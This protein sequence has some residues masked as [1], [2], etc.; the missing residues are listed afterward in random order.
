VVGRFGREVCHR[1]SRATP[2][3]WMLAAIISI[4][5]FMTVR[6]AV[7]QAT[8]RRAAVPATRPTQ[9]LPKALPSD[10]TRF[11]VSRFTLRYFVANPNLPAP[12]ELMKVPIVLGQVDDGYVVDDSLADKWLALATSGSGKPDKKNRRQSRT[13]RLGD[14]SGDVQGY[15]T[16]AIWAIDKQLSDYLG[17]KNILSVIVQPDKAQIQPTNQ[18]VDLRPAGQT[19]LQLVILVGNVR[20]LKTIASGERLPKKEQPNRI[21]NPLHKWIRDESPIQPATSAAGGASS[22]LRRD[23]LDDYVNFLNRFPAR[24]VDAAISPGGNEPGA[25]SLDYL[26]NEAKPWTVYAQ[27]SNTGTK[28]TSEWRERF[29][30]NDYQLTNHDDIFSL[31]YS[32][33]GF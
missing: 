12:A 20:Q 8:T 29:G 22:V 17:T 28:D 32:T 27:V 6:T 19:S 10:G 13:I 7:G 25:V 3:R 30:F 14:L 15:Y 4:S 1:K 33:A 2:I 21:N 24:R 18:G 11:P 26:I 5:C 16:S 23:L 9:S 31:D